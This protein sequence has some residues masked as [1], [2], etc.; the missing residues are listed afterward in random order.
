MSGSYRAECVC[1][2]SM[3]RGKR[4]SNLPAENNERIARTVAAAHED[5]PRF[6][7]QADETHVVSFKESD[8]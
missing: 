4:A 7:D 3:K 8:Q 5:R 6:G 1:G 2:W